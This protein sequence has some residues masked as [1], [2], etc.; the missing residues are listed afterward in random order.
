MYIKS[1]IS[2]NFKPSIL[3]FNFKFKIKTHLKDGIKRCNFGLSDVR[4]ILKNG[5]GF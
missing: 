2:K 1:I 4:M 5:D 3:K